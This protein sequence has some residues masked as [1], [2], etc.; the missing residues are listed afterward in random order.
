[1][2]L[3]ICSAAVTGIFTITTVVSAQE[4][5]PDQQNS[6]SPTTV[7]EVCRAVESAEDGDGL[8]Q[9]IIDFLN[10][11]ESQGRVLECGTTY[12]ESDLG[13]EWPGENAKK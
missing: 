4:K 6:P 3:S 12:A 13:T 7:E 11:L 1:M 2:N 8:Q 10:M 9:D 5:T